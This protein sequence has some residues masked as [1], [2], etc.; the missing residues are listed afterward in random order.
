MYAAF[1]KDLDGTF[2]T[3]S[4]RTTGLTTKM[5]QDLEE[6]YFAYGNSKD[7]THH[8]WSLQSASSSSSASPSKASKN[9]FEPFPRF[10]PYMAETSFAVPE[11]PND[12]SYDYAVA[13]ELIGAKENSIPPWDVTPLGRA[14]WEERSPW[15]VMTRS[16]KQIYGGLDVIQN[17]ADANVL[18]SNAVREAVLNYVR[19]APPEKQRCNA[20]AKVVDVWTASSMTRPNDLLFLLECPRGGTSFSYVLLHVPFQPKLPTS[21]Q[22]LSVPTSPLAIVVPF[23]CQVDELSEFLDSITSV[24]KTQPGPIRIIIGWLDCAVPETSKIRMKEEAT[25][26]TA[27]TTTTDVTNVQWIER[28]YPRVSIVRKSVPYSRS[29]ALNTAF[30]SL[31]EEEVAVILDIDIRIQSD[32]LRHV[33]AFTIPGKSAFFPIQFSRYNPSLV[34]PSAQGTFHLNS[35]TGLWRRELYSMSAIAVADLRRLKVG[36]ETNVEY[37][38]DGEERFYQACVQSDLSL[39]RSY[40]PSLIQLWHFK[41]CIPFQNNDAKFQRCQRLKILLEGTVK[42]IAEAHWKEYQDDTDKTS[43]KK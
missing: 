18:A 9:G 14:A 15:G 43:S 13:L 36:F 7:S 38:T 33:R 4:N 17:L 23:S 39:F 35:Q 41:D 26:S 19:S 2:C 31:K 3:S 25:A 20:K 34:P 27:T 40:E 22:M 12:P 16:L 32:Y 42:Q 5:V 21:Y 24:T 6:T 1:Q 37:D 8:V 11:G 30:T 29:V 10:E 28:K